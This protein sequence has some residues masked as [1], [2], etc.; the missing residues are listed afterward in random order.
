[1]EM[2]IAFAEWIWKEKYQ[3]LSDKQFNDGWHKP[4]YNHSFTTKE[5]FDLFIENYKPE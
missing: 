2:S 3:R 1:M 4:G 5:L